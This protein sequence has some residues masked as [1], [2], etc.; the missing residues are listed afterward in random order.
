MESTI[1]LRGSRVG[2]HDVDGRTAQH[3]TKESPHSTLKRER[4]QI[5]GMFCK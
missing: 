1:S 4:E 3:Q 2:E 5:A